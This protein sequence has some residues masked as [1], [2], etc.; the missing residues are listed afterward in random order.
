GL[1][2]KFTSAC[3]MEE[4]HAQVPIE[5]SVESLEKFC[6]EA[7]RYFFD[8][9]GLISHQLNSYNDFISHGLQELFDSLGE[10]IVEPENDPSKKGSGGW[11]HAVIK[12]GRVNL[13]KPAFWSRKNE[14]DVYFKPKQARLQ[15]MTYASTMKVEVTIQVSYLE[16]SD[17]SKK[18][19]DDFVQKRDDLNQT[20]WVFIGCLPVMVN[21]NLCCLHSLKE[22]DCLFVSGG[23]FL[24]KGMEK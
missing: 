22:S 9:F 11:K 5:M 10:V 19:N 17:G 13:E 20:H 15:N 8:E 7:S 21:S 2:D 14:A 1:R 6:R 24:L 18:G 12:F 23:Y 4:A 16:K 3:A